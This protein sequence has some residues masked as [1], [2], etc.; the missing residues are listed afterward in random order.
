MDA[1]AECFANTRSIF[2]KKHREK[3]NIPF[4]IMGFLFAF[5]KIPQKLL[6]VSYKVFLIN[7]TACSPLG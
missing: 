7:H 3:E 1:C 4:F 5:S 2:F 6:V